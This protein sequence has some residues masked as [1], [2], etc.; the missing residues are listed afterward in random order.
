MDRFDEFQ[1]WLDDF[2]NKGKFQSHDWL[3]RRVERVLDAAVGKSRIV[4]GGPLVLQVLR[5][6]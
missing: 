5:K 6:Q 1:A 3:A 2:V 4:V